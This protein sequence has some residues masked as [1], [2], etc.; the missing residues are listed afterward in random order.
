[1]QEAA[2]SFQDVSMKR[3]EQQVLQRISGQIPKGKITTLVGPSGAG[4]STLLKLC[5]FNC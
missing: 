2:I 3:G 5:S 4:K 1:M